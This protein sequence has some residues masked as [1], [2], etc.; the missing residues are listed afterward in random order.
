[1]G[2]LK[3]IIKNVKYEICFIIFDCGT[4][5]SYAKISSAIGNP[6]KY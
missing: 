1:M 6:H 4:F 2:V 3:I 5:Y